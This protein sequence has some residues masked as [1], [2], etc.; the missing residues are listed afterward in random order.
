M[1][2]YWT[3][4]VIAEDRCLTLHLPDHIPTGRALI[5]IEI[6]VAGDVDTDVEDSEDSGPP[7]DIEWWD[8]FGGDDIEI[9]QTRV[10]RARLGA[11]EV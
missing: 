11:L 9:G 7:Q 3:E 8:E 1:R 10:L 2:R 5:L 4:I 6:P